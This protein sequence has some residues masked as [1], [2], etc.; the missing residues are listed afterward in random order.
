MKASPE[1][2]SRMHTYTR[3]RPSLIPKAQ[4][5]VENVIKRQQRSIQIKISNYKLKTESENKKCVLIA[6]KRNSARNRK[7][8]LIAA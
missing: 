3:A 2:G 7:S 1:E 8:N 5:P 6:N 4:S